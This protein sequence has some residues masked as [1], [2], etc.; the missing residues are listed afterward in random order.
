MRLLSQ[1]LE[2]DGDLRIFG[3]DQGEV[4]HQV[5]TRDQVGQPVLVLAGEP[6]GAVGKIPIRSLD[7]SPAFCPI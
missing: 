3:A 5:L 6:E 1:S 7:Q 2:H 4:R